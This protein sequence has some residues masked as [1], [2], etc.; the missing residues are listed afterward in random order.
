MNKVC[1]LILLSAC[2]TLASANEFRIININDFKG[3]GT[4]LPVKSG[5]KFIIEL[6]GN[7]TTGYGWFLEDTEKLNKQLLTPLNL[8]DKNSAEFY[9]RH[10]DNQTET[11]TQ[12]VGVGGLYHFKFQA[13]QTQ[14]GDQVLTFVYKRSWTAE[15]EVRQSI[16]IK[17]VNPDKDRGDL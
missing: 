14:S 11:E 4:Y 9:R 7:P 13:S 2:C 8:D 16:N 12:R 10:S 3:E 6:E 5:Q 1:L 15:N 17:V